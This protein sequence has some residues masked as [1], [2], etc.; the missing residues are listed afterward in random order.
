MVIMTMIIKVMMTTTLIIIMAVMMMIIMVM[1]M[2]T[3][4]IMIMTVMMMMLMK[5]YFP[6]LQTIC[7]TSGLGWV[8]PMSS[9]WMCLWCTTPSTSSTSSWRMSWSSRKSFLQMAPW[10]T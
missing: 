10:S 1:V 5:F 8:W 3:L 7:T 4:M 9:S 2:M 6:R